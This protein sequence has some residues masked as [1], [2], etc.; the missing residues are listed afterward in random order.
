MSQGLLWFDNSSAP[1]AEKVS[2]AAAYFLKKYGRAPEVCLVN[3]ATKME[4]S[5]I[6]GSDGGTINIRPF[7]SVLPNHLWIGIEETTT[8]ESE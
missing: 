6:Q 8:E 2:K 4:K 7:Q 5:E 3:P 1:L